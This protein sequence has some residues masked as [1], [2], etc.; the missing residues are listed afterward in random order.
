MRNK[1]RFG[2][3][4]CSSIASRS[5]I[6]AIKDVKLAELEMIGS[7]SLEKAKRFAQ[8]FSCDKFGHYEYILENKDIDAVYI[9]LPPALNE[10]WV[11]KSALAGKHI[12]CEK[13]ATISFDSAKKMVTACKKNRVRILEGFSF[14]FHPQ[15]K[16]IQKIIQ[17]GS[18]GNIFSFS[19]SYGFQLDRSKDDFRFQKKLG[20]GI[21]NDVGCYIV[22]ASRMIFDKKPLSVLC[23]LSIDKNSGVDTM[24]SLFIK[25]PENRI[26][27]GIFSYKALFQSTY[28]LWGED[29]IVNLNRAF[30]IRNDMRP[31]IQIQTNK[32]TRELQLEPANQFKLM[33]NEFCRELSHKG[34]STFDYEEDLLT[35]A[36]VMTAAKKS[37]VENKLVNINEI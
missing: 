33:I 24:G 17:D 9:S 7:R 26:A 16:K 23:S 10:E 32:K 3:I 13:P 15:H 8:E 2:I 4:G 14:R 5:V 21:L 19:S 1:I 22:C 11:I 36:Q 25:Y 20:G 27:H 28:R 37:F 29:G 30:N 35:Q 18:L 12:I 34:S 31:S 6:P